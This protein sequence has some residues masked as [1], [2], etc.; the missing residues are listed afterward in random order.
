MNTS[1]DGEVYGTSTLYAAMVV[2]AVALL[3]GS[4]W[5]PAAVNA[6][7]PSSAPAAQVQIAAVTPGSVS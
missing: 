7:A 2:G 5:A 1:S 4:L 3:L 6:A